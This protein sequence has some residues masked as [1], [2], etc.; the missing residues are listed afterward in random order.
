M[1]KNKTGSYQRLNV[2]LTPREARQIRFHTKTHTKSQPVCVCSAHCILAAMKLDN[3]ILCDD[4]PWLCPL[5]QN[6]LTRD[7]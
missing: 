2:A 5:G 6:S 7:M 3:P 1:P 4:M